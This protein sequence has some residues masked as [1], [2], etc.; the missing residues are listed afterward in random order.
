MQVR[1][2]SGCVIYK[3]SKGEIKILLVTSS[4]GKDWVFPKGGIEARMTKRSSAAKEVYEEAGVE[5][6]VGVK[7]GKYRAFRNN[8]ISEVTVFAMQYTGETA[9]WPE[10][11]RRKRRWF[12]P[13]QAMKAL[14]PFLAPFV[15]D[16]MD[17]I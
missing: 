5:G 11:N 16:L 13:E 10:A 17:N 2:S 14:G 3:E 12:K 7:L 9:D 1:K 8:R 15:V 6:E 4:S